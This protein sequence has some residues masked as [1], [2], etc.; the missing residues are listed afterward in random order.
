VYPGLQAR[1]RTPDPR[2]AQAQGWWRE[3]EPWVRWG[4][5]LLLAAACL[6][7]LGSGVVRAID[8]SGAELEQRR[9]SMPCSEV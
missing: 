4:V 9:R 5:S 2:L 6:A 8:P 7:A 3:V 1:S